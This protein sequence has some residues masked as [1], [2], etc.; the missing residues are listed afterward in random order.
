MH[1]HREKES[2]SKCDKML[3]GKSRHLN[4]EFECLLCIFCFKINRCKKLGDA[5]AVT[6]CVMLF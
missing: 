5:F 4:K 2:K 3:M 1:A 6:V